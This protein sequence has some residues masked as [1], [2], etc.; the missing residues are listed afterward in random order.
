M[1]YTTCGACG[2]RFDGSKGH[3]CPKWNP[4]QADVTRWES[5]MRKVAA[6]VEGADATGDRLT[7]LA[8]AQGIEGESD[9]LLIRRMG[10]AIYARHEG[11]QR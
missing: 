10:E 8:C 11:T 5:I 1:S 4:S 9:G 3:T 7:E 6:P 2:A